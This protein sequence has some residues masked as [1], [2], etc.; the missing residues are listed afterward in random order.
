MSHQVVNDRSPAAKNEENYGIIS[1]STALLYL[2]TDYLHAKIKHSEAFTLKS[3]SDVP[4]VSLFIILSPF[5]CD[6]LS[7]FLSCNNLHYSCTSLH[8]HTVS[9][10]SFLLTG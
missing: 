4:E 6:L 1:T 5:N 8:P 10:L 9:F 3:L 7:A 2:A